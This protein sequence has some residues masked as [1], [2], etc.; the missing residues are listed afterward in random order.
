M[1]SWV[2]KKL[3]T[4]VLT[5]KSLK[6][7]IVDDPYVVTTAWVIKLFVVGY[8][9][10]S[11]FWQFVYFKFEV[12]FGYTN[13]Y[14]T[15]YSSSNAVPDGMCDGLPQYDFVYD[16]TWVYNNNRCREFTYGEVM[17]KLEDGGF[18]IQTYTQDTRGIYEDCKDDVLGC[19]NVTMEYGNFFV[20]FVD[21]IVIYVDHGYD[22]VGRDVQGN[23]PEGVLQN[24]KNDKIKDFDEGESLRFTLTELLN[25]AGI[26]S[27]DA[28]NSAGA[29]AESVGSP[30][31]RMTGLTI[32]LLISYSNKYKNNGKE[33]KCKASVQK[34]PLGWSGLGASTDY[35]NFEPN[36]DKTA[37][38]FRTV[39][40][41][42]YG[43]KIQVKAAGEIGSFDIYYLLAIISQFIV[44]MGVAALFGEMVAHNF[45]G[46][47]SLDLFQDQHDFHHA[48]NKPLVIS[49]SL[50]R[51]QGLQD[52]AGESADK[53]HEEA[54]S[55]SLFKDDGV[56]DAE[57]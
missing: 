29:V 27:L 21:D 5:H 19:R 51:R 57:V 30:T 56:E 25:A 2:W 47:K 37:Y 54:M 16:S 4:S 8:L 12:P 33:I 11:L 46:D 49:N 22:A 1:A 42:S 17:R 43:V 24:H 15:G 6:Y 18:Y 28:L 3:R 26:D 41:Y 32:E 7:Q 35:T 44:Y 50:K 20:P 52:N 48:K 55:T 9:I 36:A 23:N 14:A 45:L 39:E 40:E 13:I 34:I 53:E 38:S 31:Y 10:Y